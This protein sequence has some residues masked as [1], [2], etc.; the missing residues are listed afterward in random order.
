MSLGLLKAFLPLLPSLLFFSLRQFSAF[1]GGQY[2]INHSL[3]PRFP[4]AAKPLGVSCFYGY[5][6]CCGLAALQYICKPRIQRPQD[7]LKGSDSLLC[8][9]LSQFWRRSEAAK[10]PM[11]M[12]G[13]CLIPGS[14]QVQFVR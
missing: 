13:F 2:V 11:R 5:L 12:Q 4:G 14:F 3:V 7:I 9:S 8:G 6:A 1:N 10:Q